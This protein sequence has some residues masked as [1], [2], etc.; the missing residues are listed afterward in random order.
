LEEVL[1]L[2]KVAHT[3]AFGGLMVL[4]LLSGL[5]KH[6]LKWTMRCAVALAICMSYAVVDE[7]TQDWMDGRKVSVADLV[8]NFIAILGV[9]LVAR[10]P[11]TRSHGG[12]SR[13]ILWP[14]I[15]VLPFLIYGLASP[16]AMREAIKLKRSVYDSI[17]EPGTLD[18]GRLDYIT[19]G[20]IAFFVSLVVIVV[21]PAASKRP[22]RATAAALIVLLLSGPAVEVMQHFTGRGVQGGD[23][24]GHSIGVLL[25]MMGWAA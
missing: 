15:L 20:I 2:D 21:W 9:Y 1:M 22:R 6:R 23:V 4:V 10:Q 18:I 14:M 13:F 19:H 11:K 5:G 25:V 16:L 7:L 24:L 8:T 12:A 17:I 3:V